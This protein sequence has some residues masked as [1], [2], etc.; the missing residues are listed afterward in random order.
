[1]ENADK[2][3]VRGDELA[4]TSADA[5]DLLSKFNSVTDEF[6]RLSVEMKE[7][8]DG[9]DYES[10]MANIHSKLD[11]LTNKDS[12]SI[13]TLISDITKELDEHNEGYSAIQK[14][15]VQDWE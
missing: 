7:V 13:P 15:N 11:P 1:M 2:L 6:N 12:G 3:Y 14:S 10:M 8:W 9:A 4:E 5:Q